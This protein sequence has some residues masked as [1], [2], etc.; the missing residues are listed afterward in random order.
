MEVRLTA[1]QQS[2]VRQ[3]IQSGRLRDEGEAVEEAMRLWAERERRRMEI[4]AAVEGAEASLARG[5]G[6]TVTTRPQ[7]KDLVGDIRRRGIARLSGAT[8]PDE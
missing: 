1:E 6:R 8:P 3:A 4:L 2:F 5:E 7:A